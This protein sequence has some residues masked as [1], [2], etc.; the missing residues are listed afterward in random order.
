MRTQNQGSGAKVG[1]RGALASAAGDAGAQGWLGVARRDS[2]QQARADDQRT[3]EQHEQTRLVMPDEVRDQCSG[4]QLCVVELRNVAGRGVLDG[5][6]EAECP[7]RTEDAHHSQRQQERGR[8]R[9]GV[10]TG[11]RQASHCRDYAGAE[12]KA[13]RRLGAR[14]HAR[15]NH[16]DRKAGDAD[17]ATCKTDEIDVLGVAERVDRNDHTA[18]TNKQGQSFLWGDALAKKAG[19]EQGD[20][21][22]RG[23]DEDVEHGQREMAE[24]YHDAD[25][26]RHVEQGTQYLADDRARAQI[27]KPAAHCSLQ[28]QRDRHE[29]PHEG[30]DLLGRQ[31][32]LSDPL[33]ATVAEHPEGEAEDSKEHGSQVGDAG[34]HRGSSH[35]AARDREKIQEN[36]T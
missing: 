13:L 19:R 1:K 7:G 4:E 23:E 30:D 28:R 26:V 11:E 20:N 9:M 5:E 21:H 16:V 35:R 29:E 15:P 31:A 33:D 6:I 18:E 2:N 22:R 12:G 14:E 3:A 36:I 32:V 25:I 10:D 17:Q 8:E 34:F 27:A 24:G